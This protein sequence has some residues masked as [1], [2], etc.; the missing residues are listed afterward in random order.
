MFHTYDVIVVGAGHAGCEAAAAAANMGCRVMLVT[1]NMQT[2]AQ[3]SCNPA[4]GGVA[5]GQIVREIDAMGGY[6]GIVTDET[7]VQFRMLNRS[8]G[9]A[10]WSPRAQSDRMLFARKWRQLLEAHPLIDFWQ[11]M[12]SG[13]LIKD[14]KVVGVRT[15]MGLEIQG[16]S[17]VL[18]NGTFLNGLIHIGEK[19]LG[20]GRAG[21]SA[22]RGITEQLVE[23]GFEAGRMKTGTP[24]RLDGRSIDYSLME[25]QPGDEKIER[26]SF[27]QTTLPDRQLPCHIS[28]TNQEVHD[29]LKT[30]FSKSPMFTGRIQGL[31]PRYCPS[32]EDKIDRF[33]DRDRHQLFIEP[34]GWDTYE[35]YLN[36]FSSSLPEE[37][38]Y[39]A[40]T[41]IPGL[42]NVKMFRPG[43]AIEYDYF[44]PTQLGLSLETHLVKHLF[45]AGQ[46]NGTT[47]YEEAA[48]QG[49]M[50]GI[51]A[52]LG[53]KEEEPLI[54]KRSDAYIGV[55]IDDLVNK[56]T[57][58]PYRMFTSRAE[59]R[60]LLR[61]DNADLRLTP[62]AEKIGMQN[63][64]LRMTRFNQKQ[65]TVQ[66]ITKFAQNHNANPEEV[67]PYLES[68]GSSP[69]DQK[70]R[71]AQLISRPNI[72][73]NSLRNIIPSLD[74]ICQ[75]ADEES[76]QAVEIAIKYEGYIRKE[77]EMVEKMNRLETVR[78]NPEYDYQSIIA[79]SNE[80]KTKLSK[81][82]PM[83]IGQA[84]RISGV[85]PADISVLLVH[86]GR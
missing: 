46:I 14:R 50:A 43:Y 73:L 24:P 45:F 9:P 67:N 38:Q 69:I 31:G 66:K 51:N 86:L 28:Y 56:G 6:S 53:V 60:I 78:I 54:L 3:M 32:I 82:K 25:I 71:I 76:L 77:Q 65:E 39:K 36:G 55:L 59:Y 19:Q 42:A 13:L 58:E 64:E 61:Q 2:I 1:M 85:S 52:A 49:M 16:K 4:M 57:E 74:A 37:V 20:G 23:L 79:L 34:E 70:A 22:A 8:K 72:E 7:M 44:P 26:F 68:L 81:I 10:M 35:I 80:A 5:K 41:K 63:L 33:A 27:T 18:T 30:G 17:V 75:N 84:S 40:L 47:G 15:G 62:I 29:I 21:E 48:C 83:T 11:D 12:V